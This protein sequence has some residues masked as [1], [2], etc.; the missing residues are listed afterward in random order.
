MMNPEIKAQWIA[1]L[2]DPEI[3]QGVGYLWNT[4][5]HDGGACCLGILAKLRGLLVPLSYQ[6]NGSPLWG[7]HHGGED[8][9]CTLGADLVKQLGLD[10]KVMPEEPVFSVMMAAD[11]AEKV[12]VWRI[13]V[14][15][16]DRLKWTFDQIADWI[17]AQEHF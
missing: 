12:P 4:A 8:D 14:T 2:R 13:L 9:A 6:S 15:M 1:G 3:P 11:T 10:V 17:E 7:V 16:N 5:E